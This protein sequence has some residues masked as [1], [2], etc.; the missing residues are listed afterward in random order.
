MIFLHPFQEYDLRTNTATGQWLDI[1]KA[2]MQ[3]GEIT[4]NPIFNGALGMYNNCIIKKDSRVTLGV[5]SVSPTTAVANTR[6]AV[7]CGAQALSISFGQDGGP[8][9]FTWVE[10]LFDYKNQL[11]VSAGCIF[12]VKKIV[13]N[14]VDFST[15]VVSSYAAQP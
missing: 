7:F 10:E 5:S 12:G 3:G 6:R 14:S 4:K 13:F 11:G 9:K 1:Q 8:N 15:I 2:A